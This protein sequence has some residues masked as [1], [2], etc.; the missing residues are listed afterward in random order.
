MM[1]KIFVTH[2]L[3]G[4][5]EEKLKKRFEVK[6]WGKRDISRR[7]LLREV[8]GVDGIVSLLTE[9][10]DREV[11]EAAGE[12]LRVVSN[13][14]V[15]FDNVDV[16]T[17][18]ERGI[19]VTNTPGVLTEAVAEHV[20][21]LMLAVARNIVRG[22]DFVRE[23]KYR[24]WEPDL[25]VG[26]SMRG[27]T[28]G[29]VGLGSIGKWTARLAKGMG[30]EV[31]YNSRTR[32]EEF[33]MIED[34]RYV[35][36]NQLLKEADVVSLNV[37]LTAETEGMIGKKELKLMKETSILVNTARGRVMVEKD[38]V[39]ALKKG[40]IWGAGL[41][42]FDDEEHVSEE[43]RKLERVVLTPHI[44]SATMEARLMMAKI[45]YKAIMDVFSGRKPEAMVN[46]EAWGK[47]IG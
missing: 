14:A 17:A 11:M 28:M 2:D 1:K 21:A 31:I 22:D 12:N 19:V 8:G 16:K 24:G 43:L 32:N 47:K 35:S 13:Y 45:V 44:A 20:I 46:P 41:D 27:K 40:W 4:E 26:Q 34:A 6:V 25:L 38:L 36:L 7:D 42:V 9:K 10:I 39:E 37:P 29:V 23:G 15:G 5:Y 3:P 33:E 30:M 18:T